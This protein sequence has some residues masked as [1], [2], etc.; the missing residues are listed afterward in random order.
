MAKKLSWFPVYGNIQS[1]VEEMK[2]ESVGRAFLA[3]LRYFE[4]GELSQTGSLDAEEKLLL[5]MFQQG[6]KDA[7]SHSE[8]I[9]AKR[10]AAVRRRWEK[11]RGQ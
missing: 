9:S 4:N 11:E 10:A 2:P 7:R 6:I 3:A 1:A 8:E 5:C